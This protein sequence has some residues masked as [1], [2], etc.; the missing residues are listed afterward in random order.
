M[1]AMWHLILAIFADVA[2]FFGEFRRE[3]TNCFYIHD[4]KTNAR[5]IRMDLG[6]VNIKWILY[7]IFQN[8]RHH[9]HLHSPFIFVLVQAYDSSIAIPSQ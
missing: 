4:F 1:W 2:S 3:I 5:G 9:I 6:R 7:V 8:P